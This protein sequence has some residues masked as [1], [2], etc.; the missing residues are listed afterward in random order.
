MNHLAQHLANAKSQWDSAVSDIQQLLNHSD[1]EVVAL[2][3]NLFT[4]SRYARSV[5]INYFANPLK[6]LCSRYVRIDNPLEYMRL[7]K[8]FVNQGLLGN[9]HPVVIYTNGVG[10]SQGHGL[11][12][13]EDGGDA[14]VVPYSDIAGHDQFRQFGDSSLRHWKGPTDL[15][16]DSMRVLLQE[17]EEKRIREVGHMLNVCPVSS[18]TDL[19]EE[20]RNY[21]P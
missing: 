13:R 12:N 15:T 2:V 3:E 20:I 1:P 14:Q 17:Q 6:S 8:T 19:L 10:S 4:C 11:C 16:V 7:V 18:F 21:N 9:D 5:L